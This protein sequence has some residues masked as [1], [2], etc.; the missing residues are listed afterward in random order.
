MAADQGDD[1]PPAA[2]SLEAATAADLTSEFEP[3]CGGCD[4]SRLRVDTPLGG[5]P[6]E[7]RGVSVTKS[8][9][10]YLAT[11]HFITGRTSQRVGGRAPALRVHVVGT[12]QGSSFDGQGQILLGQ[13]RVR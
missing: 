9:R 10:S 11:A 12:S 8:Q 2:S 5:L 1:Q 6:P 3:I 7:P 4:S 13:V